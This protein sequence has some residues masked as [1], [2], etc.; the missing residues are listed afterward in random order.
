MDDKIRKILLYIGTIGAIISAVAY[1]IVVV[2]MIQG[3]KYQQTSSTIVF[4]VVNAAIGLM[5]TNFLR[6]QGVAFAKAIPE[7]KSIEDE[8]YKNK[9]K[10]K[11]N[12][13]MKYYWVINIT[14]DILIK[15]LSIAGSTLGLIYIIIVG[16]NDWN[17][18]LM[19]IV[20]LLLFTCFGLIALNKSYEYYN[21]VYKNYM[22]E[23]IA[24]AKVDDNQPIT[25]N[26]LEV[27]DGN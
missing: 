20:N 11:K 14:K 3:F 15:G 24:E 22:I 16:S 18:L 7:N 4:A 10:D 26:I 1:V 27:K 25:Q 13:S 19:A 21:T 17:L 12:H 5:I 8:Y 9:T 23:K 2:V 6:Y